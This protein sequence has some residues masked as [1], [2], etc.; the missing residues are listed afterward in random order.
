[1]QKVCK[2]LVGKPEG[3][4]LLGRLKCRWENG[5]RVDL[6]KMAEGGVEWIKLAQDSLV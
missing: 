3:K 2:V 4:R 6:R 1:M 5:I